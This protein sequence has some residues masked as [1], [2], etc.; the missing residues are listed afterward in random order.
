MS[1][2]IVLRIKPIPTLKPVLYGAVGELVE[3]KEV[4]P[5]SGNSYIMKTILLPA[6]VNLGDGI[7]LDRICLPSE[8]FEP[9]TK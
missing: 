2:T 9:I 8:C 6:P 5:P 3:E 1:H 4:F 7:T